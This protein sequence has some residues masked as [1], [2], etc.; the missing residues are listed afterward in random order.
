MECGPCCRLC[1]CPC[2]TPRS[3]V[4]SKVS[5][6]RGWEGR[7]VGATEGR[8]SPGLP[9]FPPLPCCCLTSDP[10]PFP[11]L[12]LSCLLRRPCLSP[13][14]ETR[15]PGVGS[16]PSHSR[17]PG[18][19][20]SVSSPPAVALAR[21]PPRGPTPHHSI[22]TG[23]PKP[24]PT[25]PCHLPAHPEWVIVGIR[26]LPGALLS[27]LPI[28]QCRGPVPGPAS[29]CQHTSGKLPLPQGLLAPMLNVPK[30]CPLGQTRG[31]TWPPPAASWPCPDGHPHP[32]T[33]PGNLAAH[34]GCSPTLPVS[35]PASPFSAFSVDV[36]APHPLTPPGRRRTGWHSPFPSH[37]PMHG[38]I[39]AQMTSQ[40]PG[41][42]APK[43]PH[44][45]PIPEVQP[46]H[47]TAAQGTPRPQEE[48]Q[49]DPRLGP[50]LTS[51][52]QV[53]KRALSSSR[54]DSACWCSALVCASPS[55]RRF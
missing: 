34:P 20:V 33:R 43:F 52:L 55:T 5:F 11:G 23:L 12:S 6:C 26:W 7:A 31:P 17:R 9:V 2:S 41:P 24:F 36:T 44:V 48:P 22:T 54:E 53:L 8:A 45:T 29:A 16:R 39:T 3:A 35:S 49:H 10:C 15:T 18:L 51:C 47:G 42:G 1:C 37:S 27:R 46:G 28:N 32:C 21:P 19:R 13:R 25:H 4:R 30:P 38:S 50:C 14:E 40:S